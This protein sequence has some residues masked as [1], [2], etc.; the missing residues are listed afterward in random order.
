MIVSVTTLGSRDG[1][2]AAAATAVVRYLEGRGAADQG[3]DPGPSPDLPG[4]APESDLVGY[5]ADSMASPGIW[6]GRGMTGVHMDGLVDPAHLH[7]VLV[8]QNPHTAD[9]LV[10]L[11]VGAEEPGTP[12]AAAALRGPDDEMLTLAEA[13]KALGVDASYLR[14]RARTTQQARALQRRQEAAGEELTPLP[15]SYLEASR[16]GPR[17]H[18]KTTRAELRRFAADREK[19]A[20]V[21]GYD[22]TF[23]APKSVSIL[24]ATANPAQ[25]VAIEAAL[26]E[27]VR[28]AMGYLEEHAA[29]VRISVSNEDG[30]G[31]HLQRHDAT[32]L[33]AAA[34]L[35]ETSRALD[36]QLHF[37]VVAANMAEGPD[38]KVR[39]LD[40]RSLYMHAKTAGYLGAAELR[41]RLSMELGVEWKPVHRGVADI[42]G[43][44]REA[45]VEVSQRSR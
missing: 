45:V 10:R 25:Q 5:Y 24:W 44:S 39:A 21:V 8:G 1:N 15:T 4:V 18:W 12:P 2:A 29:H 28:T 23:S 43:V 7:R 13:A 30:T 33:V 31:H 42:D 35:H 37:H 41:H 38:G 36:P 32:G 11:P 14:E 26:T 19:P 34:Y 22:L 20:A 27:S 9:Q 6:M 40:G 3:R 17:G 16:N